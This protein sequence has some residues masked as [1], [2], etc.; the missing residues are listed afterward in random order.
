MKIKLTTDWM[1]NHEGSTLD[2][3]DRVAEELILRGSATL[4]KGVGRPRRDKMISYA[5]N[6]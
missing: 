1:G 6:K 2:L 3:A 4:K 5:M